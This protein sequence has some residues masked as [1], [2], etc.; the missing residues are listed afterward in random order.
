MIVP[1]YKYAIEP[2]VILFV[3]TIECCFEKVKLDYGQKCIISMI[4]QIVVIQRAKVPALYSGWGVVRRYT[5]PEG[6]SCTLKKRKNQES[7]VKLKSHLD[8]LWEESSSICL[9]HSR[10]LDLVKATWEKLFLGFPQK[11]GSYHHAV[12]ASLPVNRCGHLGLNHKLKMFFLLNFFER[13]WTLREL[14]H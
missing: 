13:I 12:A 3:C 2:N 9:F 6:T 10:H 1:R 7:K 14:I 11:W 4:F 8:T 5:L